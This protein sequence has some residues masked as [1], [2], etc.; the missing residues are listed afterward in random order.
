MKGIK[1]QETRKTLTLYIDRS[2]LINKKSYSFV[3][4]FPRISSNKVSLFVTEMGGYL[5]TPSTTTR[6]TRI[7]L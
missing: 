5:L 2:Y 6:R 1:V 4:V 3:H 7:K